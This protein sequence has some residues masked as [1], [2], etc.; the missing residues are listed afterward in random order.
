MNPIGVKD[1][2]PG[3]YI[4]WITALDIGRV[5]QVNANTQI[6]QACHL[7]KTTRPCLYGVS[8][9]IIMDDVVKAAPEHNAMA[10]ICV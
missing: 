7:P 8:H 2:E 5:P 3:D 1:S 9:N 10:G 6:L 4:A